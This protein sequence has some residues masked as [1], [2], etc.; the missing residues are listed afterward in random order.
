[1]NYGTNGTDSQSHDD[2]SQLVTKYMR[3]LT[4]FINK[5]FLMA[6]FSKVMAVAG[7]TACMNDMLADQ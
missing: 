7:D 3:M 4:Q 5:V 2:S 1:M 6:L